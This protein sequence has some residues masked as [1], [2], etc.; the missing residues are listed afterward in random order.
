MSKKGVTY[1]IGFTASGVHAGLKKQGA[2]DLAL[3][4]SDR[5]AAVAGRFTR[6]V[7]KGHSLQVSR[8]HVKGG[9]ARAVMVNAGCA[10][11]CMGQRGWDDAVAI[12]D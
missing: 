3:V 2:L 1:P 10:N 8:E 4:V 5:P 7:V 9:T 12:C 6:N 11:A